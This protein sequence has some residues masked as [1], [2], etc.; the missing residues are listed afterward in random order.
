MG[1]IKIVPPQLFGEFGGPHELSGGFRASAAFV[2]LSTDGAIKLHIA[3]AASCS[4]CSHVSPSGPNVLKLFYKCP[5]NSWRGSIICQRHL[6]ETLRA[7][8]RNTP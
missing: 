3:L 4:T 7:S 6:G 2:E 8:W 1:G 5:S